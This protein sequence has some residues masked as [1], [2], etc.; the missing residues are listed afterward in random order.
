MT[1]YYSIIKE[2]KLGAVIES[3]ERRPRVQKIE[4][5]VPSRVKAMT[6][7]I[8][9]CH[10]LPSLALGINRIGQGLGSFNVRTDWDIG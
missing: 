7:Q 8:D 2:R 6:Y 10:F 4:S 9:T 1:E 3:I 5:L